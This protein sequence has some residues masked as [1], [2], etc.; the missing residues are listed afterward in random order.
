MKKTTVIQE[1]NGLTYIPNET[2]PFTGV[3]ILSYLNQQKKEET[4]YKEGKKEGL[5]TKW[6]ENG[7]KQEE[8]NFKDD[9]K[10]GLFTLWYENGQKKEEL[11]FEDGI[12]AEFHYEDDILKNVD[13]FGLLGSVIVGLTQ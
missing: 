2:T 3:Y 9:K 13:I 4:H 6:Y 7:Q 10:E 12:Q 1:R 11:H 8:G 5:T